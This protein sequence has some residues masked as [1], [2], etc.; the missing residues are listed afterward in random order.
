MLIVI[1]DGLQRLEESQVPVI[2]T[3]KL[4][5]PPA[6]AVQ[7]TVVTSNSNKLGNPLPGGGPNALCENAARMSAAGGE[8]QTDDV[9]MATFYILRDTSPARHTQQSILG[10]I[11]AITNTAM[12]CVRAKGLLSLIAA[13]QS[14]WN[15]Y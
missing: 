7:V 15:S 9:D 1:A 3:R 5:L 11:F 4:Q 8:N 2:L 12:E 13:T 10:E 6:V 14:L